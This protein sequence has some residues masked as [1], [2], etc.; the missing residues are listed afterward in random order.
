MATMED[1][2]LEPTELTFTFLTPGPAVSPTHSYATIDAVE[3]ADADA[4]LVSVADG[5][6]IS[7]TTTN[8]RRLVIDAAAL[9][10][11]GATSLRVDGAPVDLLA[12]DEVQVGPEGGKRL[13]LMGPFNAAFEQPHCYVY[14]EAGPP[15][16]DTLAA[17]LST[18]WSIIGNGFA[19]TTTLEALTPWIV[20]GYQLIYLGVPPELIDWDGEAP[21]ALDEDGIGIGDARFARSAIAAVYP[22]QGKLA[23]LLLDDVNPALLY[24]FTPFQSRFVLPDYFVWSDAGGERAG[25]FD[26]NWGLP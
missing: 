17:Y 24:Q 19:C 22:S 2:R 13:G 1:R 18:A 14:E 15:G 3:T 12:G 16:Y 23:A 7:L 25:F 5:G 26:A 4:R 10:A 9:R 8:V 11:A 6:A 21:F 20:E